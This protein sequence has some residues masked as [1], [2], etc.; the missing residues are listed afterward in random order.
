VRW[1]GRATLKFEWAPGCIQIGDNVRAHGVYLLARGA[2][3]TIGADSILSHGVEIRTSD[4]HRLH[5][6]ASGA[7]LNADRDTCIGAR[8]W[9]G[10]RAMILQGSDLPDGTVVGATSLVKHRF[11]TP[12]SV[13]AGIPARVIRTGVRWE[14]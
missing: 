4:A 2:A 7:R 11:D 6:A 10:A 12:G 8:C 13:V 14:R 9:I 5:D 1:A 3:V